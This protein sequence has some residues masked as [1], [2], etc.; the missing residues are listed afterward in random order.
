MS[1]V[2]L[3]LFSRKYAEFSG[4]SSTFARKPTKKDKK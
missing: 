3:S 1:M 4:K 2:F